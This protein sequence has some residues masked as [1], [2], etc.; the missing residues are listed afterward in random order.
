MQRGFFFII[1]TL[2]LG[3]GILGLALPVLPT[4]PFLLVSGAM[5][6]RSSDRMANWLFNHNLFGPPIRNYLEHRSVDKRSKMLAMAL[7]WPTILV[8]VL[9]VDSIG[10]KILLVLIAL[11]VS[12]HILSLKTTRN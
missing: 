12:L 2:A 5:F 3:L 6:L 4:T 7:L 9:L 8:S 10:L 11:G 1:G